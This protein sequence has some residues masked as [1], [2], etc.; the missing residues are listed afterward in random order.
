M[1]QLRLTESS[2][3]A[4]DRM[5]TAAIQLADCSELLAAVERLRDAGALAVPDVAAIADA[6][7]PSDRLAEALAQMLE[8]V[9][10]ELS[11]G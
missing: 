2:R 7:A 5:V 9:A 1:D 8:Q 11:S 3:N 6:E 10:S 4:Y